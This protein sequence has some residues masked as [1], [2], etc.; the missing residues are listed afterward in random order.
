M[1]KLY[2]DNA[3]NSITNKLWLIWGVL[4]KSIPILERDN[5]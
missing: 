1:S 5:M 2:N 4:A 3:Y